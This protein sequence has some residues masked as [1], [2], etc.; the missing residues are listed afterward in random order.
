MH[1]V[2]CHSLRQRS[3]KTHFGLLIKFNEFEALYRLQ[4]AYELR[5]QVQARNENC[6]VL[7]HLDEDNVDVAQ[8]HP[9]E[10]DVVQTAS[11]FYCVNDRQVLR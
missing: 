1:A 2:L 11:Y 3:L 10:H 4:H 7:L 6:L 8:T 9:K 5:K